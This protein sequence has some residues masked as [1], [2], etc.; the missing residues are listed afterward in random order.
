[1]APVHVNLLL[2]LDSNKLVVVV[3]AHVIPVL[4]LDSCTSTVAVQAH[5]D[6]LLFLKQAKSAVV[7]H[8]LATEQ[9]LHAKIR[10]TA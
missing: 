4:C 3:Q 8:I 7:A 9:V 5:V 1:M 10:V 2:R 6:T